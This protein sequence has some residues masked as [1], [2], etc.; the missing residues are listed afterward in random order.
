[1]PL[2]RLYRLGA[3]PHRIVKGYVLDGEARAV[4]TMLR[5]V[6]GTQLARGVTAASSPPDGRVVTIDS[7][8]LWLHDQTSRARLLAGLVEATQALASLAA[9]RSCRLLSSAVRPAG[10]ASWADWT[11]GDDHYVAMLDDVEREVA[12]NLFRSHVPVLVAL[13][14][15]PPVATPPS[16]RP[17]NLAASVGLDATASSRCRN[18]AVD[19]RWR[20]D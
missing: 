2:T 11:A 19:H 14:G 20:S 12:T 15:R 5:D 4:A 18:L 7:G 3:T 9:K 16:V 1:M 10:E 8:W 13:T 17:A 6:S